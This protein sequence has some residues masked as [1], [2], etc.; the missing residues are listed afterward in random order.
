MIIGISGKKQHGKD[1][2]ANIIMWIAYHRIVH[3]QSIE[4]PVYSIHEWLANPTQAGYNW[5]KKQF[6]GKLKE[7]VCMLIGCTMEQLED[8]TFKETPLG[9][10]WQCW[11]IPDGK[12]PRLF[13]LDV[14]I[15]WIAKGEKYFKRVM[16]PRMLLQLLG[17]DCGR[18]I[19]HPN[20]WINATMADY[21]LE[22][23][24]PSI[25]DKIMRTENLGYPNWIITDVRF[26]NELQAVKDRGGIIIRVNRQGAMSH[27]LHASETALDDYKN[28]D[29]VIENNS[30][31]D[32]LI[33]SVKQILIKFKIIE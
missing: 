31:L 16:T 32:H 10:E 15:S 25:A 21:K 24:E 27:D 22:R 19:I 3:E 18:N 5:Q 12:Y 13:P 20:I 33:E 17:T 23:Y 29:A 1:T 9:E 26:P 28:F 14:D 11:I 30:D 4:N 7:M 6:A 8:N 2:V